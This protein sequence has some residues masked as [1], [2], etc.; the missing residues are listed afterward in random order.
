MP[1]VALAILLGAL[2]AFYGNQLQDPFWSAYAPLLLLLAR[3]NRHCRLLCVLGFGLLWSS[4]VLHQYSAHRLHDDFD[5]KIVLLSGVIADIPQLREEHVSLLLED[6]AIEGY[7]G[8]APKRARFNWYRAKQQPLA[9]ELWQFQVRIRKPTG[10]LNPAGF[11]Y[12]RWQFVNA[13]DASGYVVAARE[14]RR[15]AEAP[16][17]SLTGLRSELASRIDTD[18]AHCRHAGLIKA[19]TLGLRADIDNDTRSTL[20]ASGTAHLLAISGLHIGMVALLFFALGQ[21]LWR[22]G[23][24]RWGINRRT[25]ASVCALLAALFYAGLAGFSLP[26]LRALIMLSIVLLGLQLNRSVNL[27]QSIAIAMIAILVVDPLAVGSSSFWLSFGALLV[28][29]FV[30]FRQPRV[31]PGWRQL[32]VLQCYFSL[33]FAPLGIIIFGQLNPASLPANLVAIPALSLL[34]LPVV[35]AASLLSAFAIDVAAILFTVADG[36]LVYLL[37]YLHW[38]LELGLEST[39]VAGYPLLVTLAALAAL[40]LLILPRFTFARHAAL[41][42]LLVLFCW[43]PDRPG[44]GEFELLVLD[45]GMGT[46]VLLQ[47]RNHSLVYDLGP[48]RNR[49]FNAA[50]IALL[51]VLRERAIADADLLTV[52]H[53]D[54][55]HSGGLHALLSNY[56]AFSL[57]SG[58]PREL[59]DRFDL[60]HRVRSCHGYPDWNWDGVSFRFLQTSGAVGSSTNNRSCVL[61]V[62]GYH[63]ALLP[64]DIEAV[65]EERLVNRY[66]AALAADIL[67]APHHGSATSSSDAFI[68]A[69]KPAQVVFTLSR[70]NR[71]NFPVAAVTRRYLSHDAQL[72]RSDLH[73]A[74]RFVSSSNGLQV[75]SLRKPV[76]RLWRRW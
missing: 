28:I 34:I 49:G 6:L 72:W 51:P 57:L 75:Q 76:R 71:W 22:L 42:L 47:T 39:S 18:C 53:V 44:W 4:A 25:L 31:V 68:A 38:L 54:Q 67:L 14:N 62:A 65:Q 41:A 69:V 12:E 43:R 46:S 10:L 19:L 9:G 15:L 35:L 61:Q 7:S 59:R 33:L 40:L 8:P 3:C 17:F 16:R 30:N 64:G 60:H 73:G 70:N 66:G 26:T 23:G 13:I 27:L 63:R 11:D 32:L 2:L 24:Y 74:V 56:D 21:K 50:N 45:V 48:G 37:S 36:L 1:H 5:N 20:Q 29:A 58:T 52:S 55:D